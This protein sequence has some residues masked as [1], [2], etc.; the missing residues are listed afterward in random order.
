MAPPSDR[1][2]S[3]GGV[4]LSQT[5]ETPA[6]VF[7]L[8]GQPPCA[9]HHGARNKFVY[10]RP[11]SFVSLRKFRCF[12]SV[13][14]NQ[15]HSSVCAPLFAR[16]EKRCSGKTNA[17]TCIFSCFD[18]SPFCS[19]FNPLRVC[20]HSS[21]WHNYC[22]FSLSVLWIPEESTYSLIAY[23]ELRVPA[24]FTFFFVFIFSR[25]AAARDNTAIVCTVVTDFAL[26][27]LTSLRTA[28]CNNKR[29]NRCKY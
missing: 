17:A 11:R 3:S 29:N 27:Q 9:A 16:I 4:G 8:R 24:C 14:Q 7:V 21:K 13:R 26:R 20:N 2:R 5:T 22:A 28:V 6:V 1:G 23:S 25:P 10:A 19:A 18:H 12:C 15:V